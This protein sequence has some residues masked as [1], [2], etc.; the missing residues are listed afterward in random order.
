MV[1]HMAFVSEEG[2]SA[3]DVSETRSNATA[4]VVE[5]LFAG[6]RGGGGMRSFEGVTSYTSYSN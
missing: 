3:D 1:S 4:V 5:L 2:A 6:N